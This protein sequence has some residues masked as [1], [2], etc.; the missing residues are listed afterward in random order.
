MSFQKRLT[1]GEFVVLAEMNTPKGVDISQLMTNARRIKGRV[2]A[3][4]VPDM[5]NGV[6][7]MSALAGGVLVQQQGLEAI[8][9]VYCRDRN[10]MALQGDI[11]AAHV[12]GIQNL[13]V[14]H[15]EDVANSDHRDAKPVNDLD[16][17]AL[18]ETIRSLQKGKDMSGFELEG[19]PTFTTGC[20]VGAFADDQQMAAELALTRRKVEAGA[21]FIVTP[22]VFDVE[23]YG[24]FLSAAGELGVPII[25]T[26]FLIK[27]VGIAR[28]MALNEPGA[29]ISEEMIR[30]I[31]KAPDREA[32]CLKIA[33]E[34]IAALKNKV[35]GVKIETHGW[36]HRL[37]AILDYAGL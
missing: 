10:R 35:A 30:R 7:R 3:A 6:M 14:V 33:G 4:V 24:V 22:P 32:E 18:L 2:D 17:V 29:H 20:T 37:G 28:Y 15:S 23:R 16:E 11:L 1:S 21:Q 13:V 36:E 25:A 12:L 5:D 8:I 26:I 34:T 31:R 9:H 19:T 27:S